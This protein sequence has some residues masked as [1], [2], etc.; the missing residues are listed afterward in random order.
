MI[1]VITH[2]LDTSVYSQR[3]RKVPLQSVVHRWSDLGNASL[4]I[5]TICEAEVLFGLEKKA[6]ARLRIEYEQYLK[7]QLVVLPLDRNVI[8]TYARIKAE[9]L[10]AGL[11]IGEFDLLIGATALANKLTVA[12]LNTKDFAKIP[13]LVVEDWS[14]INT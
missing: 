12:T 9:T 8:E 7:N 14:E 13:G 5:S 10:S 2:L 1:V 3:L 4:A 11:V 6:S